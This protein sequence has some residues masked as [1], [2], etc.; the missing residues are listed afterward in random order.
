MR[1]KELEQAMKESMTM[2]RAEQ[3]LNG[4]T[5]TSIVEMEAAL[6]HIAE[7]LDRCGVMNHCRFKAPGSSST[8]G[9]VWEVAVDPGSME[10]VRSGLRD[11][12]G[13]WLIPMLHEVARP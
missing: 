10:T 9:R 7:Y 3:I 4:T 2:E 1:R 8:G 11:T 12:D 5:R 6:D 13:G